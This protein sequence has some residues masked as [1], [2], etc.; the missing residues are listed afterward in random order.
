MNTRDYK[1]KAE[2]LLEVVQT[3]KKL[4]SNPTS[5]YKT[6]LVKILQRVKQSGAI[7]ETKYRQLYPTSEEV[8]M[9]WLSLLPTLFHR[10]LDSLDITYRTVK[11]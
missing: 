9:M 5:K 4:K 10:W 7:S 2:E 3:Y 8:P 1:T 11:T 6:K